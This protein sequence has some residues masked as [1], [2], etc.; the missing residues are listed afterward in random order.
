MGA[1]K[2]ALGTFAG[3]R[4]EGEDAESSPAGLT[5]VARNALFATRGRLY[6]RAIGADES[7]PVKAQ[8][9][10]L[11]D[12]I[13]AGLESDALPWAYDFF[14]L[15][16]LDSGKVVYQGKNAF[17]LEFAQDVYIARPGGDLELF[18]VA[19][20]SADDAR[21]MAGQFIDGFASIGSKAGKVRGA[22]LVENEFI[23]TFATAVAVD[24][25]VVGLKGASSKAEAGKQI[26][27]LRAAIAELPDDVKAR[28]KSEPPPQSAGG[29]GAAEGDDS[30]EA[31][32]APGN[33]AEPGG[34]AGEP[35]EADDGAG[36]T[37]YEGDEL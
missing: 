32:G 29:Y 30:D 10:H 31:E 15:L 2:N 1:A 5:F 21:A 3:E 24:R 18:A 7:E 8:L 19:K 23:G 27:R 13:D 37:P 16:D 28:A 22:P 33:Q 17:S 20:D 36:K 25:F 11:R 6:I 34:E 4:R 35:G 26:D 14:G 9:R 12:A